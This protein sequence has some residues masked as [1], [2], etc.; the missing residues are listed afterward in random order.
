MK[1][2][3]VINALIFIIFAGFF[4]S[5]E[6]QPKFPATLMEMN[7]PAYLLNDSLFWNKNESEHFLYYSSKKI[8]RD[9]I[10]NVIDNQENNITNIAK[11]MNVNDIDTLPKIKVWIF[12]SDHEKYLKTQVKSNAHSLT[13]YWSAYYNKN[14]A[15]GA[16]EIGHI[17]SQHFW[18][19]L[20][21]KKYNFLMEEGFAFYIDESK[22]FKFDFYKKAEGLIVNDKYRISSIIKENN[23]DDYE[24]KATVCGA[25]V[26]YLITN[27][28]VEKFAVLW[29]NIENEGAFNATF[30]KSLSDLENEFYIFLKAKG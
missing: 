10:K 8:D 17:M 2:D 30:S 16:H 22:F 21:T 3:P 27:F 29:K 5:C 20:K 4:T 26:K 15:T 12:N 18:G 14:N 7:N 11:I 6:P 24:D 19:Y 1:P 28:G 13:E 9:F 23:N 25:F